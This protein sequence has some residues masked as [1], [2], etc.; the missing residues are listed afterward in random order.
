MPWNVGSVLGDAGGAGGAGVG[1]VTGGVVGRGGRG[2]IGP[3]TAV[4]VGAWGW[5]SLSWLT[6]GVSPGDGGEET[7]AWS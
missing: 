6:R 1:G 5:P 3:E 2:G 4:A 7:G